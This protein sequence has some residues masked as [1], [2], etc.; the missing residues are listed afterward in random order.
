MRTVF[1]RIYAVV[2]QIPEGRVATY[3]QVARLSDIPRGA[4]T[5][6]WAM[7]SVPEGSHV[8]WWRVINAR[9]RISGRPGS[10]LA[11]IQ[12]ALLEAEG[13]NFGPDG[14]VDLDVFGWD[15]PAVP[16]DLVFDDLA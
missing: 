8:P 15:S 1:E 11:L 13:V 9:G 2:R 5:V 14:E 6:G 12:R 3:G 16:P 7:H 10:S 4:R